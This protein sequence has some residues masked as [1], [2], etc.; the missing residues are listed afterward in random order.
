MSVYV[1]YNK[2]I[3]NHFVRT[4]L[5]HV[6]TFPSK[7]PAS[8]TPPQFGYHS[9]KKLKVYSL[10]QAPKCGNLA[11]VDFQIEHSGFTLRHCP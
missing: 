7:P 9:S 2:N 10:A 1:A 6:I 4:F 8:C 5:G 11:I 3:N